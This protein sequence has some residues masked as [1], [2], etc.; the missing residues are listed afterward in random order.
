MKVVATAD[1]RQSIPFDTPVVVSELV[2]GEATRCVTCGVE[3]ELRE[4]DQLWAFK[5]Q[6]PNHHDGFVR[7]YCREHVPVV[8]KREPVPT[9]RAARA[10]A[11]AATPSA[12]RTSPVRRVSNEDRPP[13]AMCPDCYVEVSAKGVCG[14]CGNT[15]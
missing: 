15:I 7:F 14:M 8:E 13:R 6:H 10:A 9:V 1:W 2:P 5:H 11:R 3:S 4:R 12:V